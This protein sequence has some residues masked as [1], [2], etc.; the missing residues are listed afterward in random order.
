[1][2]E[3]EPMTET[4]PAADRATA[5]HALAIYLKD[6]HAGGSAGVR[7][8][9]RVAANVSPDVDGRD[10]LPR[11]AGEIEEDLGTLRRIM[12]AEGVQPAVVKD[13]MAKCLEF[14]GRFKPNGRVT[15]RARLSDVIELETLLVGITGK[16]ALWQSLADRGTRAGVDL[17]TLI[18][19]AAEQRE[20]VSRCRDS[21]ALKAFGRS[22]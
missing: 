22:D 15:G 20:V 13:T 3:N 2:G 21:A 1:V 10:E 6:H 12:V 8:A 16:A 9:A 5:K 7:L 19:R 17:D 4:L 14:V 18:A 11:V